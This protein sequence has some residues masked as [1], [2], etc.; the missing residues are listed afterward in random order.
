MY[1]SCPDCGTPM[2][3]YINGDWYIIECQKCGHVGRM[4][5]FNKKICPKCGRYMIYDVVG[6]SYFSD[7]TECGYKETGCL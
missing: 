2:S 1:N 4:R 5:A 3:F 7:C 6:N